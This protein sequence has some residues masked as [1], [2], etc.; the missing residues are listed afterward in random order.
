MLLAPTI[1]KSCKLNNSFNKF[2]NYLNI[3]YQNESI[4]QK[5]IQTICPKE[6]RTLV[7]SEI[8]ATETKQYKL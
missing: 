4:S 8:A 5:N 3:K 7:N 2:P 6:P 1:V